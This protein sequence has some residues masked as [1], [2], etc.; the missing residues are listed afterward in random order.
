M[1]PLVTLYMRKEVVL[2]IL[3]HQY[4]H[5]TGWELADCV[6]VIVWTAAIVQARFVPSC[7]P[8]F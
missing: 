5:Y 3:S 6:V 1:S 7:K 2:V 8:F 4:Q